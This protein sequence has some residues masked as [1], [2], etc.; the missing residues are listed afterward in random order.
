MKTRLSLLL[1]SFA[2]L[3]APVFSVAQEIKA[4]Q[5]YTQDELIGMINKN[6]HLTRMVTDRCQLVQDVEAHAEVLK[7]PAFQFLWGDMLAW[8]VC[9]DAN[10]KRGIRYMQ[11]AAEQ[12]L[13][14][15]LEQLGRYYSKGTLV[16]TDKK[17]AVI[18]LREA[19]ALGN[20]NA[21][22]QLAQLFV[23]GY[24][25]PYDY[26]D[27]YHW[28][29]NAITDDKQ[30]HAKIAGYLTKLEKL[31]HPRAVRKARRPLNS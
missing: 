12:G 28:L 8:G 4:V 22:L 9:V 16:Q 24:G 6:T 17:R 29:Y 11:E 1:C 10:P 2:C 7:E 18:Y 20:I 31:M 19:A 26:E 5:L 14:A 27:T 30:I 3:F 21:L 25:S 23:D 15:A 13:P